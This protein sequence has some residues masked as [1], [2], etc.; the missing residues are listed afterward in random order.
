[1]YEEI[2]EFEPNLSMR[3]VCTSL[4]SLKVRVQR[5]FSRMTRMTRTEKDRKHANARSGDRS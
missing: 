3:R 1:M 2:S 4:W 5:R